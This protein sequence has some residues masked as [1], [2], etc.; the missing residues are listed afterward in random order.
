[1]GARIGFAIVRIVALA[2]VAA[3][4]PGAAPAHAQDALGWHEL[5]D[6]RIRS[7]CP[8]EAQ[9]PGITGGTGCDSVTS[10]WSGAAFDIE[11]NR[12]LINGGGHA[13]WAGNEVYELDLDTRTMRRINAPSHPLRDGCVDAN[14][15]T[16]V[17]GRPVSRH[18]YNHLA[19]IE[20]LNLLLLVGGSRWQCGFFDNDTWTFDPAL[21]RWMRRGGAGG[22]AADFGLSLAR[23]PATGLIWA[24]DS[25]DLYAYDPSTHAWQRRSAVNDRALSSYKS[26]VIDPRR[27]RYFIYVAGQRA[28]LHYD[29]R[30]GSNALTIAERAAP[31][32]AF[33]DD[34][35]AGWAYDP[36]LD[37]LVAWNGGD[38]VHL[39]N[40]D[41]AVC[42]TLNFPGGP[43]AHEQG[44]YGRFAYSPRDDVFVTCNDI[45]EN[46]RIL[47]LNA[48]LFANGFED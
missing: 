22:P 23:D 48:A 32:C 45:D 28:L 4:P 8:A 18:T 37:R 24:R 43:V 3:G 15:S 16:Y 35:A 20:E 25:Y 17:D 10:A 11:G 27:G 7:H 29:I 1:M 46:C 14:D 36:R 40:P 5:P 38:L 31:T 2:W 44:T 12:M 41:T 39:L 19:F 13:D 30:G 33:M 34:D 9:Y 21:D 47:R 26:A 42:T 6:T